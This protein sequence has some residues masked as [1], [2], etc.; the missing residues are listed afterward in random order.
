MR[1]VSGLKRFMA[2]LVGLVFIAT[3]GRSNPIAPENLP[4][5][6]AKTFKTVFPNGTIQKLTEEE[7]NGVMVYD[8]EFRAGERDKE[9]DIA[10]DGTMMESTL[11]VV[12]TA[13]PA[14]AM[15]AIKKAAKG[16]KLGRLEWIEMRY[17][18]KDGQVIK[19]PAPVIKYAAE[20][21]RRDQTAEVIVAPNG[22]VI[23]TTEWVSSVPAK[24][25]PPGTTAK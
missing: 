7:E 10:A 3:V 9:T 20:M 18:V 4:E 14:P 5:P 16:A 1:Q 8:F 11:V 2:V 24:A 15:K 23:E 13:I 6:V 12:A 25:A 21:A 22:T 19:L 17:E